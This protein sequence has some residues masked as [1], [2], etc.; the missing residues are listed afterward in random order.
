MTEEEKRGEGEKPLTREDV[1]KLIEAHGG[2]EGLDLSG[3]NLEGIDLSG[4]S[5][6]FLDL[7]GIN[8]SAANLQKADL[9]DANLQKADL[10]DANLQGASLWKANMQEAVLWNVNLL[11]ADIWYANL[12]KSDLFCANLQKANLMFADLQEAIITDAKLQK[13]NLGDAKL[14]KANLKFANLQEAII[15]GA[16]LQKANLSNAK[17]QEADLRHANLSKTMLGDV[18]TT[19]DTRL[20]SVDW[21]PKYILGDEERRDFKTSENVYRTLKLWHT[22]AGMHSI[23]DQFHYREWAVIRKGLRWRK[24][25]WQKLWNWVF[26]I[27]CGYGGRPERVIIWAAVI[28]S[29]LAGI[30]SSSTLSLLDSFYHSAVSF[31]AL[32]YGLGMST[33]ETWVKGLGAFEAFIGVFMMSLFLITFVRKMVR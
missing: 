14:Q 13:A 26:C 17:L 15:T 18:K 28:V 7:H 19:Y 25:P 12:Q 29:G 22:Q 23:A 11:G 5:V 8:L 24:K 20:D 32:G 10:S 1:L 31:T 9:K 21:G 33:P 16:K 2:P 3:K 6:D 30:Y 27:L 4:K